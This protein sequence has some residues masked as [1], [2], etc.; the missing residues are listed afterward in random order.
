VLNGRQCELRAVRIT[1]VDRDQVEIGSGLKI[2]D[3]VILAPPA[4]LKSG[5]V[6]ETKQK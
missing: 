2:G 5:D 3:R 6:V 1:S 4:E